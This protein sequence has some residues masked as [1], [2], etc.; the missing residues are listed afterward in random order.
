MIV[1]IAAD[2]AGIPL[3]DVIASHLAGRPGTQVLDLSPEPGQADEFYANTTER[4]ARA[5]LDG[6]ADKGVLFCGTGIGVAMSAN[7]IPGIRAAQTHDAYSAT[8]ASL[9]NNAQII[10]LGA[11]VVGPELGKTIVDAFLNAVFDP[12]SASAGNVAAVDALDKRFSK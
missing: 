11:R 7:K 12:N 8:R 10:T 4:A 5:I 1:V 2:S 9:S 3:K 6:R